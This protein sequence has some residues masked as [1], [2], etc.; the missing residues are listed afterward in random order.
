MFH[1]HFFSKASQLSQVPELWS[2]TSF[3]YQ[4]GKWISPCQFLQAWRRAIWRGSE[5]LVWTGGES[6]NCCST[7]STQVLRSELVGILHPQFVERENSC[8]SSCSP[9][10]YYNYLPLK[11]THTHTHKY[12]HGKKMNL[13]FEAE[14]RVYMAN[15]TV[16]ETYL[17]ISHYHNCC[18]LPDKLSS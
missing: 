2:F 11:H 14:A 15:K 16:Q 12:L 8:F 7:E 10:S 17:L 13:H 9:R 6:A 5:D 3:F 1:P 4:S 18:K